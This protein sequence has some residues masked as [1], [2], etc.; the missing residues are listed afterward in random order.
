[1]ISAWIGFRY[2]ELLCGDQLDYSVGSCY[3]G[4]HASIDYLIPSLFGASLTHSFP[5]DRQTGTPLRMADAY[6]VCMCVC[7][8]LHALLPGCVL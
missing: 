1:M 7:G 6:C 8:Q 4:V 3:G 2:H 5:R